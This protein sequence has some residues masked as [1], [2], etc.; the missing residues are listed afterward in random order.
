MKDGC[1]T[2]MTTL[3]ATFA[4]GLPRFYRFAAQKRSRPR[5]CAALIMMAVFLSI[6]ILYVKPA[7]AGIAIAIATGKIT[8]G[9][10]VTGVFGSKNT[11]L[12][13]T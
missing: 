1:L 5:I 2:T 8:A 7:M 13:Q 3:E 12:E 6:E 9:P 11:S 4:Y 10:D